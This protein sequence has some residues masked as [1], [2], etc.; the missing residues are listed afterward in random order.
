MKIKVN[1]VSCRHESRHGVNHFT[2]IAKK[3]ENIDDIIE[4]IK[5]QSDFDENAADEYFDSDVETTVIDTDDFEHVEE[6]K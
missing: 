5:W 1:L 6:E 3:N 2:R 4:E